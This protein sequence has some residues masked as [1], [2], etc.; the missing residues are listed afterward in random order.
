MNRDNLPDARVTLH[1]IAKGLSPP[2]STPKTSKPRLRQEVAASFNYGKVTMTYNLA[3]IKES[4]SVELKVL[5]AIRYCKSL[6]IGA[7]VLAEAYVRHINRDEGH[8]WAGVDYMAAKLG[9][10]PDTIKEYRKE[11]AGIGL[12]KFTRRIGS[13]SKINLSLDKLTE[14]LSE[15]SP[16]RQGEN[17]TDDSVESSPTSGRKSPRYRAE[18]HR[19]EQDR[20]EQDRAE[21]KIPCE[22]S[23]RT[24]KP[25]S[26]GRPSGATGW[27]DEFSAD[28]VRVYPQTGRDPNMPAVRKKMKEMQRQG[29]VWSDIMTAVQH[30]KD[31]VV[32]AYDN[33][34]YIPD[35]V[36]FLTNCLEDWMEDHSWQVDTGIAQTANDNRRSEQTAT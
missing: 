16:P 6:S 32:I 34:S 19:A 27:P 29:V 18:R 31:Q 35:P 11:L 8:A 13:S 12:F 4:P 1:D 2:Y 21:S 30:L 28:F 25:P 3:E 17:S 23:Q 33:E 14:L 7:R 9:L 24:C 5:D 15:K 10:H 20:T 26:E 22:G 36:S